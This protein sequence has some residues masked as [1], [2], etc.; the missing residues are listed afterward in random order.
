MLFANYL[1]TYV[2]R[3]YKRRTVWRR[4]AELQSR[5]S[6]EVYCILR[7]GGWFPGRS[8][9]VADAIQWHHHATIIFAEFG[10]LV[11][12]GS[13]ADYSRG[14]DCERVSVAIDEPFF[15]EEMRGYGV[16]EIGCFRREVTMFVSMD[17]FV[18][19]DGESHSGKTQLTP[20][21]RSIDRALECLL[22]GLKS[23]E[24]D[25][26]EHKQIYISRS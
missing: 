11:F 8:T 19:H 9:R 24:S 2:K 10:G 18:Y 20:L 13:G 5:F 1:I 3:L 23:Q 25:I 22:R 6:T 12:A 16:C 7:S 14:P 15:D 26:S 21:A 17:G 4:E